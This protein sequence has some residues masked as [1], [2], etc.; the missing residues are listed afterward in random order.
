MTRLT[1]VLAAVAALVV[2][3]NGVQG[4]RHAGP[5]VRQVTLFDWALMQQR[6]P[7]VPEAELPGTQNEN[8]SVTG[9]AALHLLPLDVLSVGEAELEVTITGDRFAHGSTTVCDDHDDAKHCDMEHYGVFTRVLRGGPVKPGDTLTHRRRALRTMLITLSDRVSK[10][11]ADDRS[12]EIVAELLGTWC[13]ESMW[14]LDLQ[15]HTIPDDAEELARLLR[16]PGRPPR[17]GRRCAGR[18]TGCQRLRSP[19]GR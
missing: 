4:D 5:G 6:A 1:A 8:I 16:R 2:D 19:A 12:G 10:G 3:E 7:G 13:G 15:R 17:P 9:L 14:D 11:K 18:S